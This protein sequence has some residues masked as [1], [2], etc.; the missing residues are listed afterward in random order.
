MWTTERLID[1]PHYKVGEEVFA[2]KVL[3]SIRSR[4]TNTAMTWHYYDHIWKQL[5]INSLPRRDLRTVYKERAQELRDKY[6][7]LVLNYSGGVDS[8]NI[9][10]AF[11]SNNIKLD[12][13]TVRF[14]F[15]FLD[16]KFHNP[17]TLD[18]GDG[19]RLSEWDYTVKP[20]LEW[21]GKNYPDVYIHLEDWIPDNPLDL[22]IDDSI[23]E[24]IH[25]QYGFGSVLRG[26]G[27]EPS[28]K[29]KYQM[30]KGKTVGTISGVDKPKL[31]VK[32]NKMYYYFADSPIGSSPPRNYSPNDRAIEYFYWGHQNP[33]VLYSQIKVMYEWFSN[34]KEFIWCLNEIAIKNWRIY[35]TITKSILYP[36][37]DHRKFQCEKPSFGLIDK[38]R[39]GDVVFETHTEIAPIKQRYEFLRKDYDK[40][41]NPDHLLPNGEFKRCISKPLFVGEI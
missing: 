37:W 30:D 35:A 9:L 29:E 34:N 23:F 15:K 41:L 39:P 26:R 20:D 3:A 27:H 36:D 12:Q 5:D 6:D 7:Y 11:I 28:I 1:M 4:E 10:H 33:S 18:T 19:N 14:P 13:V 22:K 2:S 8:W 24:E 16:K 25:C 38:M 32:N 31:A 40:L 21:L 17:N